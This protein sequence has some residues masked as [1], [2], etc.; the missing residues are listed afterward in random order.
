L[1]DN[2]FSFNKASRFLAQTC[3]IG[4]QAGFQVIIKGGLWVIT[5]VVFT[6]LK[7]RDNRQP[8]RRVWL[9]CSF[10]RR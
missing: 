4:S 5:E 10:C 7:N 3:A 6:I 1:D 9:F 2:L 8:W